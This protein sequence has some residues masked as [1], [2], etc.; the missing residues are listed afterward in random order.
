MEQVSQYIFS[1]MPLCWLVFAVT[2]MA[3]RK[4]PVKARVK[5]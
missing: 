3:V 5:R 4:E 2:Y 1:F